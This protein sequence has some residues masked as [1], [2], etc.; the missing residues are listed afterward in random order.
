MS[1]P[2]ISI[3]SM[4]RLRLQNTRFFRATSI[5]VVVSPSSAPSC[6]SRSPMPT[7]DGNCSVI[8]R[9]RRAGSA[10]RVGYIP[11]MLAP[12]WNRPNEPFAELI[13]AE[14]IAKRVAEL[15]AQITKDYATRGQGTDIVVIGVL[16]G[17]VIFL[18]DLVRFIA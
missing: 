13:S 11:D 8:N 16:K 5:S 18:A 14:A 4:R 10:P 12:P 1:N 6:G 7:I 2:I 3:E 9:P 15:G 17:S